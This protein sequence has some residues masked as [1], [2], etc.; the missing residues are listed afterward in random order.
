MRVIEDFLHADEAC[1]AIRRAQSSTVV[2]NE[3]LLG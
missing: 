3:R 1:N 2:V